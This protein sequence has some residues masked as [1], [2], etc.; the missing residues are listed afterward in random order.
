VDVLDDT[1]TLSGARVREFCA[2]V[3][4]RGRPIHFSVYSRVDTIDRS[5]IEALSEAGCQRVFFGIDSADEAVLKRIR[6]RIDIADVMP[7]LRLAADFF[8][9][10][11]SII[12]G[13]P[14]ESKSAFEATLEFAEA[15]ATERCTH[16][17]QPQLHLLSPSAGTP[18]F[19][20]FGDRLVLDEFT[21]GTTCGTLGMNAFRPDYG[22]IFEVIRTSPL[23]AA[24]FYRYDTPD[25]GIKA[26]RVESFNRQLDIE[27]GRAVDTL[28]S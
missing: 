22:Q 21:E 18:L 28:L 16:R 10:T 14:F 20:A 1:F 13:Y 5:M 23:L 27:L 25:F 11:A 8:D 3:R 4:R 19:E 7:V 17:I 24:P 6:K 12:W 9:V 2:R 26:Q 15:C